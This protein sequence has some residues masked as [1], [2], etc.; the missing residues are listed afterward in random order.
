MIRIIFSKEKNDQILL[1]TSC[2]K[3]LVNYLIFGWAGSSFL[4]MGFLQLRWAGTPLRCS[5]PASHS[6]A[7]PCLRAQ[8]PG[9]WVSV[10]AAHRLSCPSAGGI[11]VSRPGIKPMSPALAGGFLTTGL[12]GKSPLHTSYTGFTSNTFSYAVPDYRILCNLFSA[13][14]LFLPFTYLSECFSLSFEY[15]SFCPIPC[16]ACL[17]PDNSVPSR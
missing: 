16:L 3:T 1:Y 5:A 2:L 15:F 7:F 17:Q 12:P 13:L 11:L 8:V 4:P 6:G 9:A 14:S 10:V